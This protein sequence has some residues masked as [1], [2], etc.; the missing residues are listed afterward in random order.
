MDT[1]HSF[2]ALLDMRGIEYVEHDNS[3]QLLLCSASHKWKCAVTADGGY[4]SVYSRYPWSV[5]PER[6]ER[7]LRVMNALNE[8]LAA[9]CF[10]ISGDCPMF[11]CSVYISEPLLLAQT[12]ERHFAAAAAMTDKAWNDIYCAL[13]GGGVT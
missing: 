12:V 10:M 2:M 4:L 5:A 1:L 13:Y 11:R 9:G 8:G 3:V 6:R 7:L